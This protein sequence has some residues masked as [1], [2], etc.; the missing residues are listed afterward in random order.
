MRASGSSAPGAFKLPF[1]NAANSECT[2]PNGVS[3]MQA[4]M[5]ITWPFECRSV[6]AA[7]HRMY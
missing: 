3:A 5:L 6:I 2:P 7:S 1:I 4:A